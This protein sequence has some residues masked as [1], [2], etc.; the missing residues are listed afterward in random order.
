M[1][2]VKQGTSMA[3][4]DGVICPRREVCSG[5]VPPAG[6]SVSAHLP[7][8]KGSPPSGCAGETHSSGEQQEWQNGGEWSLVLFLVFLSALRLYLLWSFLQFMF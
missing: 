7:A 6:G 1:Q 5:S 8:R 3:W 4:L 2:G